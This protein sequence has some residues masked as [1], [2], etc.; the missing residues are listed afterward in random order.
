MAVVFAVLSFSIGV[1]QSVW[2]DEAYS[3]ML[4]K[5]PA[6][7]L[8]HLTSVDTH[9]PF[10]YLL[11][12]GWASIFGW[13][14][15]TLRSLSVLSVALAVFVAGLTAR[16]MFSARIAVLALPF[17]ALAPFLMRYGFEIRMYAFAS[18]VGIL[19][20]YVL[21]RAIQTKAG[22]DQ[23]LL[24]GIYAALVALGMYTLYYLAVLWIAHALWMIWRAVK[25]KQP[26]KKWIREPWA[27]A[28]G[29]AILLFLPWLPAF[30]SQLSNGALAAISQPL[31]VDNLVGIVSFEFLYRPS[32]Q[33]GAFASL[34]IVAVIV[35][36]VYMTMRAFRVAGK[37][38]RPYLALLLWYIAVPVSIVALVSLLRPMYVERYLAHVAIGGMLYVGVISALLV[39]AK[40]AWA[41]RIYCGLLVV[42]VFGIVQLAAVGNF[43]FQR[44]QTPMVRQAAASI[45]S[46]G[47]EET[48]FAAD[49]YTAIELAYYLPKCQIYFYSADIVLKGG[50]A[51]LSKSPLRIGD[52]QRELASSSKIYYV[53]YGDAKL[54]MPSR[55][56]EQGQ[57][58]FDALH[59]RTLSVE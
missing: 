59:V 21:V 12:K 18:L 34:V 46:C 30:V 4:A 1:G 50:Y 19:A 40:V 47:N 3:I 23:W 36:L 9:P 8:V 51:P 31:T 55:L 26:L 16:R 25:Q 48:V 57:R 41:K 35:A 44:L 39:N 45:P 2:F 29:I 24:Y 54:P 17:I 20:T 5:Q 33:L 37:V 22:R 32:W 28:Y 42:L 15:A 49:P 10:F 27:A 56:Y 43:N 7:Q 38:Q 53:Y 13:S 6:A 58:D 14:E 52:P 11:L